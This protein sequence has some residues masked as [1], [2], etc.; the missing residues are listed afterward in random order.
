M[1]HLLN[2]GLLVTPLPRWL[3]PVS[4]VN[5]LVLRA[6]VI[7]TLPRWMR[8]MSGIRQS[9]AVDAMV[10]PVLRVVFRMS[11]LSTGLQLQFLRGISPGTVPVVEP[12]LRGIAPLEPEVLT[13][14]EARARYGYDKPAEAHLEWRAKQRERVFGAGRPPSDAGLHE[15]EQ[16]LG[17]L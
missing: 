6:G 9:R 13:P 12:V 15:S 14:A 4:M 3:L 2:G 10:R 17:R 7:A 5:N 11:R 16:I 1:R 8:E